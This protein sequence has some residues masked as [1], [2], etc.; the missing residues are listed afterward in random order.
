MIHP[1]PKPVKRK[2][3]SNISE[4]NRVRKGL[5]KDFDKAGITSC[6]IKLPLCLKRYAL[7]FAHTRKRRNVTDLKRVVLACENCHTVVEYACKENTGK[8]MEHFLEL[9]INARKIQP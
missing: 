9:I 6:E 4:W 3:E 8:T 2:K 7:G 1:V 5:I